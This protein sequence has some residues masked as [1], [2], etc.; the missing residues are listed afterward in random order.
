MPGGGEGPSGGEGS[1]GGEGKSGGGY[2]GIE[3]DWAMMSC[4]SGGKVDH[5]GSDVGPGEI[6]QSKPQI[7]ADVFGLSSDDSQGTVVISDEDSCGGE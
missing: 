6:R 1:S 7:A 2:P 4:S 3:D 5:V